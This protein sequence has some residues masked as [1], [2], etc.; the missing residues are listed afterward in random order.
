ANIDPDRSWLRRFHSPGVSSAF[1]FT[2][3]RSGPNRCSTPIGVSESVSISAHQWL[4]IRG[5]FIRLRLR[6]A[7]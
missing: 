3:G 4:K 2:E 7:V 1:F 6:R 5:L